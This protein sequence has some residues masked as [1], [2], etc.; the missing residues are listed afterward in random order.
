MCVIIQGCLDIWPCSGTRT[1]AGRVPFCRRC[2]CIAAG[3]P[4]RIGSTLIF[5]F[6]GSLLFKKFQ[7]SGLVLI[8]L[9]VFVQHVCHGFVHNIKVEQERPVFHIPY[10]AS[11]VLPCLP[12]RGF[13]HGNRSP[14][15][16]RDTGLDEMADHVFIDYLG[17]FFR[18]FQHVGAWPYNGHISSNTLMNCGSSSILVR[19]MKSPN[20]VFLGSLRVAC[21]VS[22][23]LFTF[24]ERNL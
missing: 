13:R 11:H 21:K 3:K 2:N 4:A 24:M 19:R 12:V 1:L 5:S 18:V 20:L 17:I 8:S 23:S 14:A 15:P 10:I 6:F 7:F 22:D 9:L 16:I